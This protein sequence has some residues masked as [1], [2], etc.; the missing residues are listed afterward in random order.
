MMSS[1]FGLFLTPPLPSPIVTHFITKTCRH[2]VLDS[3]PPRLWRN[4]WTTSY[5]C[6][7]CYSPAGHINTLDTYFDPQWNSPWRVC[8]CLIQ[9]Q[10]LTRNN[11]NL[12]DISFGIVIV[13]LSPLQ[14]FEGFLCIDHQS[15]PMTCC[16]IY[17][18][19]KFNV[20]SF[21]KTFRGR[22]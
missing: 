5:L 6:L 19:Q 1:N 15:C 22:P 16:G 2:K 4:L 12:P 13:G 17:Q 11:Q 18:L 9:K 21:L 7:N 10:I 20:M 3:L 14:K 8:S